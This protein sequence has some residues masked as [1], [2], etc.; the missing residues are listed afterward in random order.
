MRF[1]RTYVVQRLEPQ[2]QACPRPSIL[3]CTQ[4]NDTRIA[5]LASYCSAELYCMY[6]IL[7]R[8]T[9]KPG[10]RVVDLVQLVR[11]ACMC[12]CKGGEGGG[13]RR[14]LECMSPIP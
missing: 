1:G 2:P 7:Y 12:M 11:H 14:Y 8:P 6:C 4:P 9:L 5:A 10:P 13:K 3:A